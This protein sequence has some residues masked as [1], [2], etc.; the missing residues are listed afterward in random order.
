[1]KWGS[2]ILLGLILKFFCYC[3]W[4]KVEK[5][6]IKYSLV[7]SD[8]IM[9]LCLGFGYMRNKYLIEFFEDNFFLLFEEIEMFVLV[10]YDVYFSIVF[11]DYMIFLL[12][13]K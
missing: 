7:E 9:E 6:M 3:I 1:M 12:V 10:G 2:C 4:K 13:D 11:G 8:G 5:E